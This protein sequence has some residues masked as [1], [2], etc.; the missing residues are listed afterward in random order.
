MRADVKANLLNCPTKQATTV[1]PEEHPKF[2]GRRN[3]G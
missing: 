3:A 1:E 2:C